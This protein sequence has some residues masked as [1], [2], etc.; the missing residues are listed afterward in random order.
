MTTNPSLL[1][2]DGMLKQVITMIGFLP[3]NSRAL[4][5]TFCTDCPDGSHFAQ[6]GSH[7]FTIPPPTPAFYSAVTNPFRDM[8]VHKTPPTSPQNTHFP[9]LNLKV[10]KKKCHL[11]KM[12]HNWAK[13][14]KS[15]KTV[16]EV[17]KKKNSYFT[18][19]NAGHMQR[20]SSTHS[21][22]GGTF[23][24]RFCLRMCSA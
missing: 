12:D 7:F 24:N 16:L 22:P 19:A 23:P 11:G 17:G 8:Y 5:P 1:G 10:G 2:N 4:L 18:L 14:L 9:G 15:S 13:C 6:M 21:R 3:R 20:I